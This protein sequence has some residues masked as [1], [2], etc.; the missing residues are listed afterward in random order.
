MNTLLLTRH[1]PFQHY[2]ANR[3]HRQGALDKVILEE[4]VSFPPPP[5]TLRR[6]AKRL[7]QALIELPA[8]PVRV[9]R[10][11]S[12]KWMGK[13][14]YGDHDRHNRRILKEDYQK[15]SEGLDV[16][17]CK[18]VNEPDVAELIRKSKAGLIYVFGTG[19]V[20]PHVFEESSAAFI[21]MHWGWSPDY[22]GEGIVSA[23]AA[24]GK[25]ALGVTVHLLDPGIDSGDILYR[26]RPEV[27]DEDNFYSIGLKLA[28]LGTDLFLKAH[29]VFRLGGRLRG[30]PQDKSL[31]RL[32]SSK[33]MR[34]H[35]EL[36]A[37]AWSA[38]R[39]EA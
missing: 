2:C 37:R 14:Y 29:E 7:T 26:A 39:E 33:Y 23:L 12:A 22:R 34:E 11:I 15:L 9:A 20:K 17:E 10:R 4:G 25:E 21:N 19:I 3:L 28:R 18:N 30:E 1:S 24:G 6:A 16:A 36:Y 8:H 5:M 13:R 27:D 31:G 35:P 38:L 32:Y